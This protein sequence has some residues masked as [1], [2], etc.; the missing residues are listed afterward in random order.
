MNAYV[1]SHIARTRARKL[2]KRQAM[3]LAY[4]RLREAG[5][6]PFPSVDQIK[7]FLK[8]HGN[9]ADIEGSM[10]GL[11][12]RGLIEATGRIRKGAGFFPSGW[13]VTDAGRAM[14]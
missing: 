12:A 5:G 3:I 7:A 11:A 13:R 6:Q 4:A 2:G 9:A 10:L 8:Y 1:A 14:L